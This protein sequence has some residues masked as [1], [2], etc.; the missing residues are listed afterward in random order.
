[1]VLPA[2]F[3]PKQADRFAAAHVETHALD[4][5]AA[6]EALLDPV[7]REEGVGL[8]RR[9]LPMVGPLWRP[10]WMLR[11]GAWAAVF[12]LV[13]A[14]LLVTRAAAGNR[15][16]DAR[17]LILGL[18]IVVLRMIVLRVAARAH[19]CW[20]LAVRVALRRALALFG[21]PAGGAWSARGFGD[22]CGRFRATR[23]NAVIGPPS[24]RRSIRQKP[25]DAAWRGR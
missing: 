21:P 15:A 1:M 7:H 13:V 8:L 9:R 17:L 19:D 24:D 23:A 2:P 5:L 11:L 12:R 25:P 4:H 6:A 10:L 18:L 20:R 16:A 3:G 14:A 22:F